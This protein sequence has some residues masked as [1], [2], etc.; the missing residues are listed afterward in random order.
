M[1]SDKKKFNLDG[2]D[3]CQYYFYN[4]RKTPEN[5]MKRFREGQSVM[6]SGN[7]SYKEKT[8]LA[9]LSGFQDT[10]RY[11]QTLEHYFLFLA[12]AIMG[13]SIDSNRIML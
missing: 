1:F 7:I 12:A 6:I 8:E 2:L 4:L 13:I 11:F 10:S 3:G 9:F 5:F